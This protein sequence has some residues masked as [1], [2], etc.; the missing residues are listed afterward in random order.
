[1]ANEGSPWA[2]S[3]PLF[4]NRGSPRRGLRLDNAPRAARI[5]IGTCRSAVPITFKNKI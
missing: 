5:P 1:L 3:G 2:S 4:G